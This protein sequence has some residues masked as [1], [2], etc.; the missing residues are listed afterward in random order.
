MPA[1]K[2]TFQDPDL[3]SIELPDLP[4]FSQTGWERSVEDTRRILRGRRHWKTGQT[5]VC[6]SCGKRALVGRDDLSH[7][8]PRGKAI[9]VYRRLKGARCTHCDAQLLEASEVLDIEEEAGVGFHPDYQAK[10]TRIGKGTL[11][12]YWPKD[13]ERLL[14]LRPDLR[15]Y[16][17]I[18][19]PDAA[20]IRLRPPESDSSA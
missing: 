6:P 14:R 9:L 15:V 20:L 17:E 13:V 4:P 19:S 12:T 16:I 1:P 3:G 5:Y 11:G 7:E 8:E 18:L 2:K 10:V